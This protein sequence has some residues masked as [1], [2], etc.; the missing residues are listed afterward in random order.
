MRNH[1][2]CKVGDGT[3]IFLW[4]DRVWGPVPLI[5]NIPMEAICQV[6]LDPNSKIKD[7]ISAGKWKWPSERSN[8]FCNKLPI[9][10]PSLSDKAKD[11]FTWETNDGN[12]LWR[13]LKKQAK[14]DFMPNN[15]DAIMAAMTHLRH[16][17]SIKSVL[18]RIILA[19]CVYFIWNERNKRLFTSDKKLTSLTV[20]R[21]SQ[22][23]EVCKLWKVVLDMKLN[24]IL[25]ESLT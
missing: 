16:N 11:L 21:T 3:K 4:H 6:G 9:T 25:L 1:V 24:D 13:S 2:S 19:A 22:T 8:S 17:R 20:K 18:R 5:N 14:F 12:K 23:K 7:M 15:W 10:V